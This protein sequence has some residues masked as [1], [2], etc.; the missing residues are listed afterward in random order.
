[1]KRVFCTL[2]LV[3]GC[4]AGWCQATFKAGWNTYQTGTF[5]REYT[6]N[7]NNDTAKLSAG[8]SA[9]IYATKDSSVIMTLHYPARDKSVYKTINYYNPKK[10]ILKTEEYKDDNMTMS[11]EWRYDDKNRK[12]YYFEDNKVS[13]RNFRKTYDYATDKKNGD[14]VVTECF[15]DD[16]RIEFYTKAYYDK[17]G[18]KYK[19]VRLN[20]NNKDVVHIES[21]IYTPDGKLKERSV[22]FPEWKVTRKFEEKDGSMPPKCARCLPVGTA[23]KILLTTRVAFIKKLLGRNYALLSDPDCGQYEYTFKNFTNCEIIVA[24]TNV[25]NMK[26]VTFRYREKV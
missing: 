9:Q 20:D 18:V 17:K 26:R 24:T 23:E 12:N 8:D 6:Y 3:L 16:G 5:T 25:N 21:Y 15:Y 4:V 2:L 14:L 10:Q 11:Y 19:E 1:M 13:G 7:F 22:Y